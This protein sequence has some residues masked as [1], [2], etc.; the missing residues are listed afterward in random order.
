MVKQKVIKD[1]KGNEQLMIRTD[2]TLK[3]ML[4]EK[5]VGRWDVHYWHPKFDE[6]YKVLQQF[7]PKTLEQIEGEDSIISGDHVRKSRNESKGYNLD[8]G[9]EYYETK[10][11]L[12]AA[13]DNSSIKFCSVN[14]YERLKATAIKQFDILV[15]CAGVGGV[16]KGKSCI[17]IHEPSKKSCTGDVFIIRLKKLNP[18][19]VFVFL[20]SVYGHLQILRQQAGTGTVNINTEQLLNIYIP[21][22]NIQKNFSEKYKGIAKLHTKAVNAKKQGENEEFEKLIKLEEESFGSIIKELES[23]IRESNN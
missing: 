5:P 6:V 13:Y 11:F 14:A 1:E 12:P 17:V 23:Y 19:Y 18:Y 21:D 4:E 2:K 10:G 15:S 22:L 9:I 20:N 8:T 16:G 7:N 3:L